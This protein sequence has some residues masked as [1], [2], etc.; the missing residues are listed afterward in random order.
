MRTRLRIKRRSVSLTR[1]EVTATFPRRFH[2]RETSALDDATVLKGLSNKL[3]V[4]GQRLDGAAVV[5]A[6]SP[7]ATSRAPTELAICVS[8]GRSCA[9]SVARSVWRVLCAAWIRVSY[10]HGRDAPRV[11]P[12]SVAQCERPCVSCAACIRISR[13]SSGPNRSLAEPHRVTRPTRRPLTQ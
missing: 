9:A 11:R 1:E 6:M 8:Y 7:G 3:K 12:C 5:R 2:A 10:D 13:S 4:N